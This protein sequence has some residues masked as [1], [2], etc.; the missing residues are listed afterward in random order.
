MRT[1][2]AALALAASTITATAETFGPYQYRVGNV[3]SF[4]RWTA[5]I[6]TK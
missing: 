2:F 4:A 5:K 6:D 3:D 1:F